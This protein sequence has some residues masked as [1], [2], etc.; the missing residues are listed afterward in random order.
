M[1]I[2]DLLPASLLQLASGLA[3]LMVTVAVVEMMVTAG[4]RTHPLLD[5]QRALRSQL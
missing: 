5:M 2:V 3:L 4:W 1:D